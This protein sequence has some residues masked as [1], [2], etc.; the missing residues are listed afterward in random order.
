L[1]G[2]D[3]LFAA[4]IAVNDIPAFPEGTVIFPIEQPRMQRGRFGAY[5]MNPSKLGVFPDGKIKRPA[6]SLEPMYIRFRKEPGPSFCGAYWIIAGDLRKYATLT[7]WIRGE[8]GGENFEI[9]L[10]DLIASRR[11]DAIMGGSIYRYLPNGLTKEWQ[12]VK[13]PLEDF[14]GAD[15]SRIH[16][17]V[18]SVSQPSEGAFWVDGFVFHEEALVQR[19]DEI[20]RSGELKLDDFDHS[21]LNLLG[22]KTNAYKKAPSF[23]AATRVEK[24]RR[25]T[26]G[27]SLRL[28]YDKQTT[29]WAGYFSLFNQIDGAY[30][31]LSQFKEIRFWVR[32]AKGKE[33]FEVG[34]SDR[35]WLTIGDSVKCGTIDKYLKKGVTK[36]WQE[37]VIPFKD[38][39]KLDWSQMGSFVINFS[40]PGKGTLYVDDLRVIRKSDAELLKE[41]DQQ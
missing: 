33:V 17:L 11:E 4:E 34:M 35:S 12:Q 10:N 40:K 3:T 19:E 2:A 1:I 14:F 37:V 41:W 36:D 39:G 6:S 26:K 32:G 27:A 9:G 29:G 23:C 20:I 38:F 24:P 31:D 15:F 5:A 8:R 25:G 21:D 28:D 13:I 18:F 16:S 22:R 7:F 30:Y